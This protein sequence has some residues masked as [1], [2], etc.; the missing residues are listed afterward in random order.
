[1]EDVRQV[2]WVKCPFI[3]NLARLEGLDG[4]FAGYWHE[5][6]DTYCYFFGSYVVYLDV[7][8]CYVLF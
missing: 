1:M 6:K 8:E 3:I 7:Q 2:V 4:D 5:E